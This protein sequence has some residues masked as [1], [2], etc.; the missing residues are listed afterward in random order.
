MTRA[1][2]ILLLAVPLLAQPR[3][4]FLT[5]DE[6]EQIREAQEPNA[7]VT[8]YAKFASDR[9]Q[10][11]KSLIAKDRAGRSTMIH[12][13]LDDYSRILDAIDE[14]TDEALA[15]GADLKVGLN[16]LAK[17]ERESLPVLKSIQDSAPKDLDRYEFALHTAIETTSDSL[18][19]AEGDLGQRTKDAEAREEREK[20]AM[21]QAMTPTELEG[22]K[23]EE[24]QAAAK[25]AEQAKPQRKPPT[26]LRP[27]EK[28]PEKKKQ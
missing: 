2:W 19:L 7:R 28:A 18:E 21:E 24:K 9:V 6:A 27:G 8:V 15:R 10:L 3:R 4:D 17:V 16:A 11:V 1:A 13:A 25:A 14:V 26:L 23:A 22:K 12:D 20:K 5:T